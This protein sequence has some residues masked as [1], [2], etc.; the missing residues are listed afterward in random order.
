[1]L[2]I[3]N[4]GSFIAPIFCIYINFLDL[5]FLDKFKT[6][7]L[8]L[9]LLLL[10]TLLLSAL[11]IFRAKFDNLVIFSIKVNNAAI[12]LKSWMKH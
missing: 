5:L 11:N 2:A 3:K 8:A 12:L 6:V 10:I 4:V 9:L 1:M 7:L